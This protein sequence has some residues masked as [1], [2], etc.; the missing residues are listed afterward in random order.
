MLTSVFGFLFAFGLT[1][2]PS[3]ATSYLALAVNRRMKAHFEK[4]KV[5]SWVDTWAVGQCQEMVLRWAI[6]LNLI[7]YI[8]SFLS[9]RKI[10]WASS[11]SGSVFERIGMWESWETG[12]ITMTVL[13]V[14]SLW[15]YSLWVSDYSWNLEV[16][17]NH[18]IEAK[19]TKV[20][21]LLTATWLLL[22]VFFLTFFIFGKVAKTRAW[23]Y[24]AYLYLLPVLVL[25][26]FSAITKGA[27]DSKPVEHIGISLVILAFATI[28]M[29]FYHAFRMR[30]QWTFLTATP[31][32]RA[33]WDQQINDYQQAQEKRIREHEEQRKQE[34][35]LA[36][37]RNVEEQR[38]LHKESKKQHER[39]EFQR[40]A[41]EEQRQREQAEAEAKRLRDQDSREHK[42]T[43]QSNNFDATDSF[44]ILG[45]KSSASASEIKKAFNS[46]ITQY[47]PDKLTHFGPEFQKL[48]NEKSQIL[49]KAYNECLKL[50]K[51]A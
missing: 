29:T 36:Q 30:T 37:K 13:Y 33:H 17:P 23:K 45:I 7:S 27:Q 3:V 38:R 43:H 22:P 47:H 34:E 21:K 24:S 32:Q 14:P 20:V 31:E 35:I 51:S 11:S 44:A 18:F 49:T 46:L 4:Q 40:R 1:F 26:T 12:L 6:A 5:N 25:L 39:E 41:A 10:M 8:S 16:K 48:A 50:K 9:F 42:Q 19:F 28:L 15:F 2:A